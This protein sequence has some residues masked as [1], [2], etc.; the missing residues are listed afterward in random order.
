MK[1]FL[2][3]LLSVIFIA[4]NAQQETAIHE[5]HDH[6]PYSKGLQVINTGDQIFCATQYG[7]FSYDK[8]YNSV[9]RYSKVTGLSDS[10]IA[11][12]GYHSTL[13]TLVIA[14]A[15]T[16]IDLLVDGSIIN[17]SDIKRK[18]ILGNKTINRITIEGDYAYL[19]CGFGIVVVDLRRHEIHDTY[20]LGPNGSMID[21]NDVTFSDEK[22]YAATAIGVFQADR[23]NTMLAVFEN[24][25]KIQT[26]PH[27]GLNY[28]SAVWFNNDLILAQTNDGY[29]DDTIWVYNPASELTS[30]LTTA[31]YY[32]VY[33]LQVTGGL[34]AISYEGAVELRN[35]S[36]QS[37]LSVFKPSDVQLAPSAAIVESTNMIW[38]A[39]RKYGLVKVTNEGWKGDLLAPQG[40]YSN[41]VFDISTQGDKLWVAHGGRNSTW[42]NLYI[43]DG[44]SSSDG[45]SWQVFNYTTE[46][47]MSAIWDIVA[48]NSAPTGDKTYAAIWGKGLME[49]SNG[50]ITAIYDTTN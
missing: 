5:W 45:V 6:L 22:I 47:G 24:W 7:L 2:S 37:I 30:K 10:E 48:V 20:I 28:G 34:L 36:M 4:G 43:R 25:S 50:A 14:Y 32:N 13:K 11:D 23:N 49:I 3:I 46:P 35:N 12:I 44:L 39:D 1:Y 16:N 18:N 38:I 42:G 27:P 9:K 15:N 29:N 19:A 8:N 21:I 41:K 17:L 26:I 33:Q 31:Y 40:P